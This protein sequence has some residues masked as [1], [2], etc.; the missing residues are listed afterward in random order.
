MYVC[1]NFSKKI[2]PRGSQN[3]CWRRIDERVSWFSYGS[4]HDLD[5]R[6]FFFPPD[7]LSAGDVHDLTGAQIPLL[8]IKRVQKEDAPTINPE[9]L[10]YGAT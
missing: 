4:T 10:Q 6:F 5:P 8:D 9:S 3:R 1:S 7:G 2:E